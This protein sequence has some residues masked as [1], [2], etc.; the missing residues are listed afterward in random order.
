MAISANKRKTFDAFLFSGVSHPEWS[1]DK[2]WALSLVRDGHKIVCRKTLT[3]HSGQGIVVAST[4]SEL[5]DAPL[6]VKFVRKETEY[7]VHVFKDQILDVQQKKLAFDAPENRNP[8]IRNHANG[9]V[10]ARE[11][12]TTPIEVLEQSIKAIRAVGLDFG[13]VD[14][15]VGADGKVYV[16]EVNSAPGIENTTLQKYAEAFRRIE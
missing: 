13:A 1:D 4:E 15:S 16:F 8:Y 7:R 14:V 2:E 10:F 12:V 6:Y 9:W 3:G 11:G 5:V